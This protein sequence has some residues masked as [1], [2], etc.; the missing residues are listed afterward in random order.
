MHFA[1]GTSRVHYFKSGYIWLILHSSEK[2]LI[3]QVHQTLPFSVEVG[4]VCGN[5]HT[6]VV[7]PQGYHHQQP[8]THSPVMSQASIQIS[9][10]TSQSNSRIQFC[11]VTGQYPDTVLL[12]HR[13]IFRYRTSTSQNQN[14]QMQFCYVT[15]EKYSFE[16]SNEA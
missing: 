15:L 3:F 9:S 4:L 7:L 6:L 12:R 11:Y 13:A 14:N 8:S 10:L 16:L 1:T 2:R 5:F